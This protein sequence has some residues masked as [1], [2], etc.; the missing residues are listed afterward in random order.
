MVLQLKTTRLYRIW[1]YIFFKPFRGYLLEN[2]YRIEPA[3][4]LHG[5]KYFQFVN[6]EEAPTGRQMAALAIYNEMDMRCSRD[7][8]ELH[9]KAMDKILSDPKKINI[10]W[11]VQLNANLKDRLELMVVPDFIYKLAS[12]VFFDETESPYTYDYEYNVKKIKVWKKDARTLDFFLQTPLVNLAPFLK[13][14]KDVSNI[15]SQIA[16][17][18]AGIHHKLLSDILLEKELTNGLNNY[19]G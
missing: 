4:E 18:V 3:F 17:Q 16:E 6:Q 14:Q 8:L 12:V 1:R 15:F 10:N 2:K 19:T 9:T 5:K 7:Y 13:A 11:I